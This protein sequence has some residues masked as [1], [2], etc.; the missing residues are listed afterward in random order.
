MADT[1]IAVNFNFNK[2]LQSHIDSGAD[3]T[4]A[5]TKEEIPKALRDID[6]TKK[7]LY[8]TLDIDGDGRVQKIIVNNKESG[9]RNVSMNIYVIERQL[10]IDHDS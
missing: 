10:L 9:E 1:N 7:D 4:I 2:L 8:Y 3:V 6:M 5:Y